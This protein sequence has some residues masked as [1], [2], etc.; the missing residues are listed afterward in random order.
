MNNAAQFDGDSD[1]DS[2]RKDPRFAKI[3]QKVKDSASRPRLQVFA[4]TTERKRNRVLWFGNN[5]S[6]GQLAIEYGAVPW[7]D[8]FEEMV[9]SKETEGRKWRLGAD[10]W[11]SLDTSIP[12]TVGGVKR[13]GAFL[14]AL[15]DAAKV[16]KLKLD[17]FVA[18]LLQ[19][20]IEIPM[21]HKGD[22]DVTKN[23]HIEV[24]LTDGQDKGEWR[25]AFGP[26][27]LTAK[28]KVDLGN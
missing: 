15:H 6:P 13:E 7:Q 23:L 20:G 27:Q 10:F 21:Q 25:I 4:Q 2:L 24:E 8:K 5:Q 17:G 3:M 14:L 16:R 19:G 26:H 28:V 18:H 9:G 12:M 11:T 1:L 22:A